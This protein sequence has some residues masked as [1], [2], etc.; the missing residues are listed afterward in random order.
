MDSVPAVHA[1]LRSRQVYSSLQEE[2][3]ILMHIKI[4]HKLNFVNILL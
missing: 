2:K 1:D 4:D 3:G